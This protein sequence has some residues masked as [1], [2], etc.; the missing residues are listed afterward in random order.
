MN[1]DEQPLEVISITNIVPLQREVS[2]MTVID[3]QAKLRAKEP[4]Q[5]PR[6]FRTCGCC[7]L[8]DGHNKVE[9]AHREGFEA[10]PCRVFDLDAAAEKMLKFTAGVD[11]VDLDRPRNRRMVARLAGQLTPVLE[12]M[13]NA[14][15]AAVEDY[16]DAE[17]MLAKAA[18][19]ED[20]LASILDEILETGWLTA[21]EDIMDII[22]AVALESGEL[23]LAQLGTDLYEELVDR[24]APRSVAYARA[25]AGQLIGNGRGGMLQASTRRQIRDIIVKGLEDNIGTNA[26]ADNIQASTS[27][28]AERAELIA[29]TEVANANSQG[30]LAGLQLASEAGAD[31][32]KGWLVLED[33]CDICQ[34]NADAGFIALDAAFPSG[35]QC[36]AA[37]PNCRCAL[38][39]QLQY[40]KSKTK[41]TVQ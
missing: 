18:P 16:L 7:Y 38:T 10:V 12:R 23:Q 4:V 30:S 19:S 11:Y 3:Y 37:H 22:G 9:A 26:I 20:E 5:A 25:R 41:E 1:W 31:I 24:V 29:M 6:I 28:S 2:E 17:K 14:A 13:G 36:P 34:Q 39:N 21:G 35:D 27:F 32:Q 15:A 40:T 8:A 33:G